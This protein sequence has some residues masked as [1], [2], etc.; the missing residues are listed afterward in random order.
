MSTRTTGT[1]RR[2]DHRSARAD[3][4]LIA[5]I[6]CLGAERIYAGYANTVLIRLLSSVER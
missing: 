2:A 3:K 6:E 5:D 4:D 1:A